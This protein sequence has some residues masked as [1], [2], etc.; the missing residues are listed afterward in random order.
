MPR[1]NDDDDDRPRRKRP[2]DDDEDDRPRK[3]RPR[4]D[5]DED[6]RPSTRRKSY[7][8]DDD[9]T[10]RRKRRKKRPVRKELNVVGVISLVIGG[11]GLIS[12]F[13][14]CIASWSL[15]PSGIGLIVG[16]I[17][18]IVAQRSDGRQTPGLA[19]GGMSVS[20]VAVLIG[21]GWL[22]AGKQIERQFEKEMKEEQA[23]AEKE[24]ESRNKERAKAG[25][26]VKAADPKTVMRVTAFQFYQAYEDDEDRADRTYKNKVLEI[27]GAFHEVDFT[28]ETYAVVLKGGPDQFD[29][30]RCEFT[31]DP[32]VRDQLGRL[33]P[34]QQ[35]TIR[36]KCL[37]GGSTIEACILV[38]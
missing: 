14:C 18:L 23:R 22:V 24:E 37:G 7:D 29:F 13:I 5:E 12:S 32:T 28:G 26:E 4:D 33:R 9:D 1:A 10:V 20:F 11:I 30:V 21:I 27:T 2:R 35:V 34:G 16:F 19:I 8:E 36:G 15:I 3:R 31:K 17:G 38:Q 25:A 6:D